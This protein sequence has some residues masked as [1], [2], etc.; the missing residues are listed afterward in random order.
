MKE[1]L[2]TKTAKGIGIGIHIVSLSILLIGVVL[3]AVLMNVSGG[4]LSAIWN[5]QSYEE[6]DALQQKLQEEAIYTVNDYLWQRQY[7]ETDGE[8]DSAK[9]IDVMSFSGNTYQV[10]RDK[11]ALEYS[12]EELRNWYNSSEFQY[13][14]G[15]YGDDF[16]NFYYN[17]YY[18]DE[19]VSLDYEE[20]ATETASPS[21]ETRRYTSE[22]SLILPGGQVFREQY[23]PKGYESLKEYSEKNNVPL[24]VCYE[25]LYN[26]LTRIEDA[27]YWYQDSLE[28]L[29]PEN[30]NLRYIAKEDGAIISTN[31][32]EGEKSRNTISAVTDIN[33]YEIETYVNMD[34][35]VQDEYWQYANSYNRFAGKIG[36]IA[37]CMIVGAVGTL[38]SVVY[39]TIVAGHV[40]EKGG[41]TLCR[42]DKPRLE[43]ALLIWGVIA[44]LTVLGMIGA[45]A[46]CSK[47]LLRE[48]Y[49]GT[50]EGNISLIVM[51]LVML[52]GG[53]LSITGYLSLVRR[54]KAK[55]LGKNSYCYLLVNMGKTVIHGIK[56]SAKL[57]ALF[58]IYVLFML[59]F[60][61]IGGGFGLFLALILNVLV[62]WL[63]AKD[64][65]ARQKIMEGL[66]RISGGELNH[67]IDPEDMNDLHLDMAQQINSVGGGLEAAVEQSLKNERMKTDLITNV[68]HDIK[69]PLTSIIN[70][71]DLL[72]RED[73]HNEKAKGY[74]DILDQKSQRLKHLTEDLVE[75]SK[76]S[77]GN[78]VL[79]LVRM[80]FNEILQQALGEFE[81]RFEK[82]G[83]KLVVKR[84]EKPMVIE[85]DGRR[86]WRILE[87]LFQ[88]VVKYAMPD[89]RVYVELEQNGKNMI[90][91]LKNI[92]E[93][94]LNINADELTERFI[95]G[96]VSRSTE[97][98][99]LG[100]S[101]AK[102]LTTIQKGQFDIYLDGDLFKVTIT[103]GL[104]D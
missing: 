48:Y 99:G 60:V 25:A 8:F 92:S 33:G 79:E 89:T 84:P 97:G 44:A 4:D 57:M 72:K 18:Y 51:I 95:R 75:A 90:F 77:S 50:I 5:S 9:F 64:A 6:S 70:Y 73:I 35:P 30:T 49:L 28:L 53:A 29:D 40:K 93:H 101:I 86:I 12:V 10:F 76:I 23:T 52:A 58:G 43:L 71:V 63:I 54:I 17:D 45:G 69:T 15:Y 67:K 62:G 36:W 1:K 78:V 31:I 37:A 66:E 16:Y 7:L 56:V 65:V 21:Q 100:L 82:R 20:I 61:L 81:E 34:Y 22:G 24:D 104:I 32:P 3:G 46:W 85:A 68:S 42:I 74:I 41:I 14:Y 38:V 87:N 83:L 39:L 27:I 96:D 103:F 19:N 91:T 2:Y 47:M 59:A 88:N 102:N 11:K 80:D 98:S 26:T 13:I 94:A 55:T